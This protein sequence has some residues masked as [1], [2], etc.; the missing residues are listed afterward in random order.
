VL[1]EMTSNLRK[2]GA[3]EKWSRAHPW[4]GKYFRY[5]NQEVVLQRKLLG[6][7]YMVNAYFKGWS[8]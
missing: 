7:Q 5:D 2:S 8:T 6:K 3:G 1:L 4:Q